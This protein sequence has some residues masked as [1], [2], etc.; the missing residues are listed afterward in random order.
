MNARTPLGRPKEDGIGDVS[1]AEC[2]RRVAIYENLERL[3][4]AQGEASLAR[5]HG[6]RAEYWQNRADFPQQPFLFPEHA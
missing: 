3:F 6:L 1:R 4:V 2:L 5:V